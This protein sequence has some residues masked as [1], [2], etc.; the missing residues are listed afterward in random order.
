[1]TAMRRGDLKRARRL[2][3]ALHQLMSAA[4]LESNPIP[5]KAALTELGRVGETVRSPLMPLA[6]CHRSAVKAALESVEAAL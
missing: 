3:A 6:D 2:Q 1:V 4:F 5:I